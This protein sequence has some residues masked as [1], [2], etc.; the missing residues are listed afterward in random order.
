MNRYHYRSL[1]VVA[2]S[3][4][5]SVRWIE[6]NWTMHQVNEWMAY[7]LTKEQTWLEEYY[8]EKEL[9]KSREMDEAEKIRVIKR[10]FG[11]FT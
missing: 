9:E 3:Q 10:M 8:K 6:D 1:F 11:V 5:K 2:E 4:G 7:L